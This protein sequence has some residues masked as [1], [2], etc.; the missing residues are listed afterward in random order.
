MVRIVDRPAA[1]SSSDSGSD[2]LARDVALAICTRNRASQLHE[3][4]NRIDRL[5]GGEDVQV[6][7]VDQSDA[8]DVGLGAR[9][10]GNSR[11][12]VIRDPGR[13]LSRARNI[14]WRSVDTTW[15]AFIDD[16]CLLEESWLAA[17][18]SVTAEHPDLAYISGDVRGHA[19][20]D[21]GDSG[22]F[23][24]AT[25][26]VTE[27]RRRWGRWCFPWEI[28]FGVCMVI[29]RD[30]IERLGG[31]DER[32]GPG[33][34]DFPASDDMDFNYRLLRAGAIAFA[35]PAMRAV[36]DQWRRPEEIVPL[37]SG[38]AIAGA[39]FSMKLL[40]TG[41]AAGGLWQWLDGL[42]AIVNELRAAV[43]LRS[44]LR[45]ALAV[46]RAR[47]LAIGTARGL[48]RRW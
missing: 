41:D 9:E 8:N 21:S 2:R 43:R 48:T 33:V 26:P 31:W 44:R 40:K 24:V 1:T 18:R 11:L 16:D 15:V 7:V 27:E 30:W 25:F 35:T 23:L 28:G 5:V 6:V 13:G 42:R 10:A 34:P 32:L 47:G 45:L 29:R 3:T 22:G 38:Y 19:E 20:S 46:A 36:H 37:I 12:R 4:L 14:A 39:G 17:L